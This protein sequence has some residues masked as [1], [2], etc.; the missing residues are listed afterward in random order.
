[1]IVNARSGTHRATFA[2]MIAEVIRDHGGKEKLKECKAALKE[3]R[4]W[5][6][7]GYLAKI[8]LNESNRQLGTF[9][10]KRVKPGA[11]LVAGF[12]WKLQI[13]DL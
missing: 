9:K 12:Q 10:K 8:W 1:M 7:Q 3:H 5:W 4:P 6:V 11:E 2:P 13:N